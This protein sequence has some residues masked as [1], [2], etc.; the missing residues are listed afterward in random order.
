[1]GPRPR[2]GRAARGLVRHDG[3]T[4]VSD[5]VV[6]RRLRASSERPFSLLALDGG[7]EG[8]GDD[9]PVDPLVWMRPGGVVVMDDF[10]PATE[11]PPQFAG[12]PGPRTPFLVRA[13]QDVH[14]LDRHGAGGV[15]SGRCP[16]TF[17]RPF[18]PHPGRF[19]R[20]RGDALHSTYLGVSKRAHRRR[21]GRGRYSLVDELLR[22]RSELPSLELRRSPTA[23]SKSGDSESS[24]QRLRS[25]ARLSE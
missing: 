3:W 14:D 18:T 22:A 1:M 20:D 7:G 13:S 8:K 19:R 2:P 16:T 25:F 6:I 15:L 5:C 21:I 12:E 24:R 9:P 4:L 10:T 23:S 11:W 17:L